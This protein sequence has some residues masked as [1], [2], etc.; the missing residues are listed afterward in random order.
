M[1]PPLRSTLSVIGPEPLTV[2]EV[3]LHCRIDHSDDDPL[4]TTYI[5]AVREHV[6]EVTGR[7]LTEKLV[8]CRFDSFADVLGY[9]LRPLPFRALSSFTYLDVDE[10]EQVVSTAIYRVITADRRAYITLRSNQVWPAYVS[11][12]D[13]PVQVTFV[14][15]PTAS[16][17]SPTTMVIPSGVRAAMLLMIGDLYENR[18]SQV[19]GTIV[20]KNDT[21]MN[22]LRPFKLWG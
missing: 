15:A 18:E 4:L 20:A 6:E 10:V 2:E 9:E 14:A 19:V 11:D 22:L 5:S 12:E 16:A 8:Q 3:R 1:N 21:A 7:A 17:G 13:Y